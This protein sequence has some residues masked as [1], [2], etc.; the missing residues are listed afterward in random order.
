[1]IDYRHSAHAVYDTWWDRAWPSRGCPWCLLGALVWYFAG[2]QIARW[3]GTKDVKTNTLI[4]IA[5]DD[6]E[7][8]TRFARD[9]RI[10]LT[11]VGPE[12]PLTLGIVD[13]FQ[14]EGLKIFGPS[15]GAAQLEGS[16]AFTKD[17]M[18]KYHI[19]SAE[20]GTFTD[21]AEAEAYIKSRALPSS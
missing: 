17:L 21:R 5:A 12:M 7:G 15:K 6:L 18:K 9:T 13:L 8:L 16:K 10:D 2:D 19:P 1:M 11:V 20:Y 14:K 3:Y 4:A